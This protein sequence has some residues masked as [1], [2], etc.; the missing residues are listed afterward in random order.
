MHINSSNAVLNPQTRTESRWWSPRRGLP[1]GTSRPLV[2]AVVGALAVLGG[3]SSSGDPDDPR[4]L[5]G[6]RAAERTLDR[7]AVSGTDRQ[8]A[9]VIGDEAI[10]WDELRASLGEAAGGAVVEEFVLDRLLRREMADRSITL[11]AAEIARE[12]ELFDDQVRRSSAALDDQAPK[13]LAQVRR[14]RGLGPVRFKSLLER[15]ATLRRLVRD[16]VLVEEPAIARELDARFGPRVRCRILVTGT[17]GEA[18]RARARLADG[19]P[20]LRE[21][22]AAQARA[23]SLDPSASN[24]GLLDPISPLDQSYAVVVRNA[25]KNLKLGE[26]SPIVVL[27]HGYA[28]LMGEGEVPAE[29]PPP[30]ARASIESEL[31]LRQERIAMD[32]LGQ[33]LMNSAQV[34]VFDPSLGWSWQNR[35]VPGEPK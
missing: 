8:P 6:V 3:C 2:F 27:D 23:E 1:G 11:T 26:L 9:A 33:R 24:G 15:N 22:F 28:I 12:R 29:T 4:D 18:A 30:S 31:R 16:D 35:L 10:S 14:A 32:R 7:N 25:L 21:R 34:T 19:S 5:A 13:L 17:E 20:D